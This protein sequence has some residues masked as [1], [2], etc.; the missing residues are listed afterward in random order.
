M[1]LPTS[2]ADISCAV[3]RFWMWKHFVFLMITQIGKLPRKMCKIGRTEASTWG[4]PK[5]QVL[6]ST[7]TWWSYFIQMT[8]L[9]AMKRQR[10]MFGVKSMLV[11]KAFRDGLPFWTSHPWEYFLGKCARA[12]AILVPFFLGER[13][14]YCVL[15][16]C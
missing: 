6:N 1:L 13:T 12:S 16:S 15:Q 10:S 8:G 11:E 5:E 9:A 7:P 4:I 3:T 2:N 14:T